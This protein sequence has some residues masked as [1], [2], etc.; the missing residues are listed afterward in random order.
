MD[1]IARAI[2]LFQFVMDSKLLNTIANAYAQNPEISKK[3]VEL[4]DSTENDDKQEY[5]FENLLVDEA[6]YDE[7]ARTLRD[8]KFT[9]KL[10][11]KYRVILVESDYAN[12]V[13]EFH[14]NVCLSV[15]ILSLFPITI[16]T[17]CGIINTLA[18]R[19]V[20]FTVIIVSEILL[21]YA[22]FKPR[23]QKLM[24]FLGYKALGELIAEDPKR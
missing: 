9:Q 2:K 16:A 5:E 1:M 8:S 11:E 23:V 15:F 13:I 10:I 6:N 7:M 18:S 14:K 24:L 17:I 12:D 19:V 20:L 22:V 3:M 4:E 21:V